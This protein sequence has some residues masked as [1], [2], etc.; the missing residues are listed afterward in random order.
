MLT[1]FKSFSQTYGYFE[2][3]AELASGQ[4]MWPAFWLL[5]ADGSWPP[6]IDVVETLGRDPTTAYTTVHTNER[7]YHAYTTDTTAMPDTSQGFHTYGASW[8]PDAIDFYIDGQFVWGIATPSD[9]HSPMYMLANLA[10]GAQG[11]WPGPAAGETATIRIDHIRA[12]QFD[13][14]V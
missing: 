3:R 12:Y 8:R 11:S 9:L 14:L 1:T 13:D 5:P 10:V 7:G 2:I 4:G 6:E